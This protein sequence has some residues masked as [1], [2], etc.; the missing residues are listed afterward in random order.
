MTCTIKT[1]PTQ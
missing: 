1:T